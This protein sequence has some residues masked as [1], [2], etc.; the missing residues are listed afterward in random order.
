MMLKEEFQ[1]K[2]ICNSFY[3]HSVLC[4]VEIPYAFDCM[5][6]FVCI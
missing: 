4:K 6:I 1:E 2:Y 5:R 3:G